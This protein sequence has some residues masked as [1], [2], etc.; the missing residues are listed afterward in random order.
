MYIGAEPGY[1]ERGAGQA[2]D[3]NLSSRNDW[4]SETLRTD[5]SEITAWSMRTVSV[6]DNILQ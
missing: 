2:H 5:S 1:G 3:R 4:T 6:P